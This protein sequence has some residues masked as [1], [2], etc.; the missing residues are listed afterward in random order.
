MSNRHVRAY[1]VEHN[2]NASKVSQLFEFAHVFL[3]AMA[4]CK[5]DKIADLKAGGTIRRFTKKEWTLGK[6]DNMTV[7]MFRSV[8]NQVNAAL[9]SWQKLAK[10]E[11]REV[12]W[13]WLCD[14]RITKKEFKE[15][16]KI[17]GFC[18]W[19][20][21]EEHRGTLDQLMSEILS[22]CPFPVFRNP[23]MT[24]DE[25]VCRIEESTQAE[26]EQW[27]NIRGINDTI[28]NIPISYTDY[29]REQLDNGDECAVTQFSFVN[30]QL[31][32]RRMVRR[33]NEPI[34]TTGQDIGIDWGLNSMIATS[35]GELLGNCLYPW[36]VEKDKQLMELEAALRKQGIKPKVSRRYRKLT[37][38]IRSYVKNEVG[39][40]LNKLADDDIR[41]ITVEKLDFRGGGLS[42][43]LNRIVSRAGRSAF[44]NKLASLEET[45]GITVNIV[46]PAYTSQE[47]SGCGHVSKKSRQGKK[48][49]CVFCG[50][51]IDADVN[52]SR[53]ILARRSCA[54]IHV[55]LGKN[56][57][58]GHL[59]S[60]FNSRWG[61]NV[62]W[63]PKRS[64]ARAAGLREATQPSV[65]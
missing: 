54:E 15:L 26:H 5:Q 19:W 37:N 22:R 52:A 49:H 17:N 55:N 9:L 65:A 8:E 33:D 39:R 48:Y 20:Q 57:V 32:L 21:S 23:C 25:L 27:L 31:V 30:G 47:C 64:N 12:L 18:Q 6:P 34:R 7:R 16:R 42:K 29:C 53:V 44:K 14:K 38:R 4:A 24:L 36:L 13:D 45:H 59:E 63:V 56:K 50:K 35:R 60:A 62:D 3:S 58:L 2:A 11:G 1:Q 28:I 43:T 46:N 41:S 51:K 10:I 40:V 61:T